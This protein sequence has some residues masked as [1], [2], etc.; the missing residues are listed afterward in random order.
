VTNHNLTRVFISFQLVWK[1][2]VGSYL[3][4]KWNMTVKFLAVE[5]F[6]HSLCAALYGV[7][8]ECVF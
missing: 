4:L 2:T 3:V 6:P 7:V 1:R 5:H 8:N